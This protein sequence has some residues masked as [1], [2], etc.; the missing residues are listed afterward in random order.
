MRIVVTGSKGMLG[1]FVVDYSR[2]QG[3]DV[4]G[5][6]QA[7]DR[8]ALMTYLSADLTDLGQVY[9]AISGAEAIIHLAA[10]PTQRMFPGA[11]TFMTNVGMSYNILEAAARLGIQRVVMAS[12]IQVN[13]SV[14]PRRP[15]RY[16]YLPLDEIHPPNPQDEYGLSKLIGET[17]ADAFAT[18]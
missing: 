9:D 13:H 3:A 18:N 11:R 17:S 7:A 8:G 4:L 2:Q 5:V 15:I 14:T 1:K 10:I 6:D 12:S 16:Q